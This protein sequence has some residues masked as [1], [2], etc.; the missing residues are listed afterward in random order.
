MK[1]ITNIP[2]AGYVT[3][4]WVKAYLMVSN[5]TLYDWIS[6]KHFPAPVKIGPRA[7]RFLA[8]DVRRFE[9]EARLAS[10]T[11]PASPPGI[12]PITNAAPLD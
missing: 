4:E 10:G 1:P 5:A 8:E 2:E 6:K 11:R 3:C 9:Q 7:V 12:A